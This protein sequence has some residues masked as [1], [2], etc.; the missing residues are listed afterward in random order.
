MQAVFHK[1]VNDVNQSVTVA[2]IQEMM[3]VIHGK[4][5]IPGFTNTE[6]KD[7]MQYITVI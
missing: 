2:H 4:L 5:Y 6:L 1:S 7:I 3:S